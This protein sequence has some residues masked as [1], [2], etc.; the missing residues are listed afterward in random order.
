[1][2][3]NYLVQE[4]QYTK[5]GRWWRAPIKEEKTSLISADTSKQ[6]IENQEWCFIGGSYYEGKIYLC[7]KPICI[8]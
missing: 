4:P 7:K 2:W 6:Y 3:I 5:S 8:H 1:M